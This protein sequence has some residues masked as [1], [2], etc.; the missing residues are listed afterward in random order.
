MSEVEQLAAIL[1]RP[2]AEFVG[3]SIAE[4]LRDGQV[5]AI[6]DSLPPGAS[7]KKGEAAR[8]PTVEERVNAVLDGDPDLR[9]RLP[10]LEAALLSY[11]GPGATV[12]RRILNVVWDDPEGP[13]EL[14]VQVHSDLSFDEKIDLHSEFLSRERALLAPVR[15][16]LAIGFF[17]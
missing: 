13:D 8:Y 10:A 15:L 12:E 2:Q 9:S 6:L 3:R 14:M 5:D 16:R 17:G 4:L 7:A 1:R 11:F